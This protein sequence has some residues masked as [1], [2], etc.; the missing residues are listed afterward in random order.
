MDAKLD[1]AIATLNTHDVRISAVEDRQREMVDYLKRMKPCTGIKIEG[2]PAALSDSTDASA[3]KL[4]VD[5][6][7]LI[8]AEN[9]VNDVD[10]VR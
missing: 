9:T 3:R 8:G 1:K 10:S 4:C 6:L 5:V 7:K 2:I